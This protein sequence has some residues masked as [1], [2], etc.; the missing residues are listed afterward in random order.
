IDPPTIPLLSEPQVM[1]PVSSKPVVSAEPRL[2][3]KLQRIRPNRVAIMACPS[4]VFAKPIDFPTVALQ[5]AYSIESP[6]AAVEVLA[7]QGG[8]KLARLSYKLKPNS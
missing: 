4:A 6:K 7:L 8:N 3:S 1:R 2:E 5:P